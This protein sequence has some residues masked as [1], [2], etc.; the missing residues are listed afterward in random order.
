MQYYMQHGLVRYETVNLEYKKLVENTSPE[1]AEY[2]NQYIKPDNIYRTDNVL[3]DFNT[4]QKLNIT[5]TALTQA[6]N[7]WGNTFKKLNVLGDF[8]RNIK[9]RLFVVNSNTDISYREWKKSEQYEKI[10]NGA[11]TTPSDINEMKF[12]V[13]LTDLNC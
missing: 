6:I 13:L 12:D 9:T 2:L 3:E 5:Q 10:K 4:I 8:D 11:E 1:L 7:Y